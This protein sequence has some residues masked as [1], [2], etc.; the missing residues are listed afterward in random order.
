MVGE[1][2][3]TDDGLE[4]TLGE[5]MLYYEARAGEYDEW[6]FRR[7]RYD[8]GPDENDAWFTEQAEVRAALIK[9]IPRGQVADLACG[10]GIW[11][12]VLAAHA[13]HVTAVDGSVAM[14]SKAEERLVRTGLA[15]RVTF[16]QADLFAWRPSTQFDAVFLGFFLSHVPDNL[17]DQVLGS[18]AA[19][20]K[21]GGKILFIDSR[22]ESTASSP[23][24]PLPDEQET[25]MT[26]RLNDGRTYRIVKI[27]RPAE[28]MAAAL[29]R[30]G[31]P[32]DVR[33]T[34]RYFQYGI[35][36]KSA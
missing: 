26:R 23:D 30:N 17:L 4:R 7:G 20:L 15:D 14:L 35:G 25:I 36:N 34:A 3:M 13:G 24:Q 10:T 27:F 32:T 5:Q 1:R 33:E 16:L 2:G 12:E 18:V 21:P 19:A 6:W 28:I 8:H 22:R 9:A 31:L 29:E 11:T